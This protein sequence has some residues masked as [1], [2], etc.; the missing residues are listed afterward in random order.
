MSD[1]KL[2][3]LKA[4]NDDGDDLSVLAYAHSVEEACAYW[5][6][7]YEVDAGNEPRMAYE[8]TSV[9]VGVGPINWGHMTE[10][11]LKGWKE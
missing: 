3:Y 7:Y 10:H 11:K 1:L 9:P 6:L 4:L 2:F 5:R 8:I